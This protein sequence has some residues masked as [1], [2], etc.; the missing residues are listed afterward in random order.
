MNGLVICIM[1]DAYTM[2]IRTKT[3]MK[4]FSSKLAGG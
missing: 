1:Y 3:G 2:K 4:S